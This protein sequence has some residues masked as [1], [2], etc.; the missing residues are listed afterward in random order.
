M[1]EYNAIL[2][3]HP[4]LRHERA[5]FWQVDRCPVCRRYHEYPAGLNPENA[6]KYLGVVRCKALRFH[7]KD[8]K[9]TNRRPRP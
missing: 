4:H 2:I 6:E 9:L 3:F 7:G 1:D 8:F 5:Y